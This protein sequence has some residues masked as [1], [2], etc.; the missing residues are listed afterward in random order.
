MRSLQLAYQVKG[1]LFKP[2]SIIPA[3]FDL[4]SA[5]AFSMDK[6]KIL[7]FG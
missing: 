7:S 3:T 5:N 4:W 6:R 2:K 1:E